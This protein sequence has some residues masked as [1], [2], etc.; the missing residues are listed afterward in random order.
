MKIVAVT[1]LDAIVDHD[2]AGSGFS[3]PPVVVTYGALLEKNERFV[4]VAA[5]VLEGGKYRCTTTI[6]RGMVQ[7]VRVL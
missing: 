2:E 5:E 3:D 1:W 6:P 4:R 7:E